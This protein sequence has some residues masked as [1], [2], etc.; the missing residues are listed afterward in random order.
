M[1]KVGM[2]VIA[3]ENHSQMYWKKGDIFTIQGM[4][5]ESC[6]GATTIYIGI[7]K[8]GRNGE[9]ICVCK[10]TIPWDNYYDAK[11]F[12]P[13]EFQTISYTKVL[14]QEKELVGVN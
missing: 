12:K 7:H 9:G 13:L 11:K 3:V 5:K 6:C 8:D 1:F 4:K 14:E 10:K 2:Q